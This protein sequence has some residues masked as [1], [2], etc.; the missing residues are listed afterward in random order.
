MTHNEVVVVAGGGM[1]GMVTSLMLARSGRH[2]RLVE[3]DL[4][5]SG[6]SADEA[7][8]ARRPGVAQYHQ[9]HAF[10]PRAFTI[11]RDRLPDVLDT[12]LQHGAKEIDLA[13]ATGERVAG[14][15]DLIFLGARRALIEWA[16]RRAVHDEPNIDLFPARV[17]G[18][19]FDDGSPAEVHGLSTDRGVVEGA[20][21]VDAMGR[22][23][24]TP[25]W[26]AARGIDLPTETSAV[27]VV[28]YSR[29][30][31]L[32]DGVSLPASP[33][34][35]GP[36]VDHGYA[37][38][39]TFIGDSRTYCIVV[40]VPTWDSELKLMRRSAAF[41]AFCAAAPALAPLVDAERAE[42]IT[43]VLPMGALQTVWNGFDRLPMQRLVALGDSFCHTDPTFAL[44]ISNAFIQG[45][46]LCEASAAHA[47]AE[48]AAAYYAQV[49]EELR[50][51][52]EFARDVSAARVERMRGRPLVISRAGCY[53]L[54]SLMATL[55]C[56]GLDPQIH[57]MAY[58]RH[59]FLD[60]LARFDRDEA[61]QQ[62]VEELFAQVLAR[63]R[64]A[65]RLDRTDLVAM[66][67]NVQ[68]KQ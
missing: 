21:V 2:V 6:E 38:A 16:L 66:I 27:G 30:Y 35:F 9:P 26:L 46:A 3:R 41:E 68:G 14:D 56:A 10:M 5:A 45:A 55:S 29:H 33:S 31:R 34:P 25:H 47:D 64:D 50:E 58:R 39:A 13:P 8:L 17:T 63:M 67:E 42:P 12:L 18:L 60:R 49:R 11:L 24:P 51:R 20:L 28:Y 43:D 57:R 40:M 65:P 48:V 52:F 22:T 15:E 62:K 1:A 61:L 23:T 37:S 53:P 54:Y 4:G 36:R 59:G 7:L 19:R 32:R 44:G